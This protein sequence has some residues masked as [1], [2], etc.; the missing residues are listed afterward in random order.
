MTKRLWTTV[1]DVFDFHGYLFNLGEELIALFHWHG[2]LAQLPL[3]LALA[4]DHAIH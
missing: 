4:T 2:Q 3:N 1:A